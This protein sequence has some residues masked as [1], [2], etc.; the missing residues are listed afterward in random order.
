MIEILP[1]WHPV[2][3]HFTVALL[4]VSILV[5]V[6][7]FF[8]K[9]ETSKQQ[10]LLVSRWN[11]WIA[12]IV[13]FATV[14]AG[15]YAYNSVNH[16]TPSHAAMTEHRNWALIT[17]ALLMITALLAWWKKERVSLF[18]SG[19]LV[20]VV[21][22]GITAWHGGELVYRYGL[23][24]MSLPASS[25]DGHGHEHGS[26]DHGEQRNAAQ[27]ITTHEMPAQN[28][29]IPADDHQQHQHETVE[30]KKDDNVHVHQDGKSHRH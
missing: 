24:V 10:A 23:G 12:V 1:N 28:Q 20:T 14:I 5:L 29:D 16:D 26:H 2:F 4:S 30:V 22:L 19:L 25:G 21:L 3:V 9:S 6:A 13:T 15:W 18:A 7:S 8:L 27:E 17:F 11:F